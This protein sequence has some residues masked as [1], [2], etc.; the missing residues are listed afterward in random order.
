MYYI[1][2]FAL[3][4]EVLGGGLEMACQQQRSYGVIMNLYV[5]VVLL[6]G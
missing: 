1:C 5:F 4:G 2:V 3:D 6:F